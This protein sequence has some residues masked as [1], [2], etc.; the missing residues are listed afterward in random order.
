PHGKTD[1]VC[2]TINLWFAG[3]DSYD[4]RRMIEGDCVG[5]IAG[6]RNCGTCAN[7]NYQQA[8]GILQPVLQSAL[9]HYAA[10]WQPVVIS[11]HQYVGP[12]QA[13]TVRAMRRLVD[14]NA[15]FFVDHRCESI[16]G[17]DFRCTRVQALKMVDRTMAFS[18]KL[19]VKPGFLKLTIHVAGESHVAVRAV[20]T[21][22]S[23]NTE[24][25]MWH[26]LTIQIEPVTVE[27]PGNVRELTE[28]PG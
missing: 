12:C 24:A 13:S 21:P 26:G 11:K 27:P 6:S 18:D 28:S 9:L 3:V 17:P 14:Q 1:V 10:V 5:E 25:G 7:F 22:L 15:M 16:G 23:E 2:M 20:V 8:L 19:A 4:R